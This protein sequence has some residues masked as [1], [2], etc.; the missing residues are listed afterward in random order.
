M[1]NR[2]ADKQQL[3]KQ[4]AIELLVK[5]GFEGFSVN[6]LA[7]AC[8]ISVATIYIYYK[9]KDDLIVQVAI[10]EATRLTNEILADFN[11]E[12]PFA[13][14][15]RQQWRSRTK[16]LLENPMS[17]VFFEQLRSSTYQDKVHGSIVSQFKDAMGKFM[18]NAIERGEID[19]LP[20]EVYWSV[21]YAPMY[22]LIRFH[23][24]GKSIAGRNFKLTEEIMSQTC[25]LVIKALKKTPA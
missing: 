9:D 15:I 13:E 24:E 18:H 11:P 23:N 12:L 25:E 14:G 8:G 7:K 22:N 3:V 5:D 4:K 19:P 2:D 10:E 20:L 17:A 21:A 1:R 16:Q 6:K